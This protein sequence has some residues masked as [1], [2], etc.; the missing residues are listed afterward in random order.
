MQNKLNDKK[1][2][3]L[4]HS[5]ESAITS[6][7]GDIEDLP[8][9]VVARLQEVY[10]EFIP[11]YIDMIRIRDNQPK[12]WHPQQVVIDRDVL[13]GMGHFFSDY[14]HMTRRFNR[15]NRQVKSLQQIDRHKEARRYEECVNEIVSGE[16]GLPLMN[17]IVG[18]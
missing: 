15:I 1:N 18:H 13:E 3:I 9:T 16:D 14:Q 12:D 10:F 11:V 17:S 6:E 4:R 8:Q 5:V 2:Q 7:F